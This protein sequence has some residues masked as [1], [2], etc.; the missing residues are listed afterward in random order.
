MILLWNVHL[1]A[2]QDELEA[3]REHFYVCG[4]CMHNEFVFH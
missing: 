1:L 4:F 3:I 2:M